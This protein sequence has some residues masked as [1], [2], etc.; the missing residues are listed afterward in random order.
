[1]WLMGSWLAMATDRIKALAR[2]RRDAVA[3][4]GYARVGSS[5]Q[6]L[7]EQH[8]ELKSAGVSRIFSDVMIASAGTSRSGDDR[9]GLEALFAY[10]RAGDTVTVVALDRL[11]RSLSGIVTTIEHIDKAGLILVSL[12]DGADF[13][14]AIGKSFLGIF[15]SLA[16]YE[17]DL[18]AERAAAARD[19]ARALGK[20]SRPRLLDPSQVER[21]RT[22]RAAGQPIAEICH[23]LGVSKSTLYRGLRR[24]DE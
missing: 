13:S 14:T 6:R 16:Q 5:H 20:Q 19:A 7:D 15:A 11:G 3:N 24:L 8:D 22:L 1:M 21:A 17:R 12:R 4:V 2:G 18:I 23:E 9:P 10:T